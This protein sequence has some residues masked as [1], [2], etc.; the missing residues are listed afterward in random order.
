VTDDSGEVEM[1]T[2]S[3]IGDE[4]YSTECKLSIGETNRQIRGIA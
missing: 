4:G 2:K 1:T 3:F